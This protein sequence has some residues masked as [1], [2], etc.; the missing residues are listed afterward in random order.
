M[1]FIIAALIIA[2]VMFLNTSIHIRSDGALSLKIGVGIFKIPL[3]PK[4]EKKIKLSDYK[5][6]KFR[7]SEARLTEKEAKKKLKK[8]RKTEKKT[9]TT[10]KSG[11]TA[12]TEKKSDVTELIDTVFTLVKV[13]LARFG[14]HLHIK[15]DRLVIIIG[16]EDAASTAIIYG[17]VCGAMQCLIE[18][19]DNC[20]H[21]KF[22][23]NAEVFVSPDFTAEKTSADIDITFSLRVWQILD[24]LIR[25]GFVYLKK[26][27]NET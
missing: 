5:I 19:L 20:F 10:E 9:E 22:S 13:F 16:S 23:R 4:K 15:V 24:A 8:K 6:E 21:T 11:E 3:Y 2:L 26:M 17:A 27:L 14:R 7:Q 18:L 25:T 12:V 1:G